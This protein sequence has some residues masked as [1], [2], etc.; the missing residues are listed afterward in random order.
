MSMSK[1]IT[2]WPHYVRPNYYV[3]VIRCIWSGPFKWAVK[4]NTADSPSLTGLVFL[5]QSTRWRTKSKKK[6][7]SGT[8]TYGGDATIILCANN[9]MKL[10][11]LFKN[12]NGIKGYLY[13]VRKTKRDTGPKHVCDGKIRHP[14]RTI[15]KIRH[16][17]SRWIYM[18]DG[19]FR[20][21][22]VLV[23]RHARFF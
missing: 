9:L 14:H 23:L 18:D 19:I 12:S 10:S 21:I 11:Q 4:E 7:P 3:W 8:L 17:S 20:H 5:I 6:S 22:H 2:P 16:P 1:H 15:G 13:T